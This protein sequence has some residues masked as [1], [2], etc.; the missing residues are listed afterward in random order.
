[1]PIDLPAL[2]AELTTDP[3][4][5]GYAPLRAVNDHV[6]LKD[7]INKPSRTIDDSGQVSSFVLFDAL[8]LD[9]VKVA[10]ADTMKSKLLQVLLALPFV[11][12]DAT[13]KYV[14]DIF[15]GGVNSKSF[16]AWRKAARKSG[17]RAEELG[18]GRVTES[19]VAD[20]LQ[21]T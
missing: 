4:G 21:R 20:A 8:D 14:A 9:E 7:L 3:A 1:M 15:V 19:D 11:T 2:K 10:L 16:K 6:G 12:F 17:S 18:F 5:I 13:K